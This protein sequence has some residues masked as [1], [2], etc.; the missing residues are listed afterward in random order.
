MPP[1]LAGRYTEWQLFPLINGVNLTADLA[2]RDAN[3]RL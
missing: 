2:V 1:N 3:E